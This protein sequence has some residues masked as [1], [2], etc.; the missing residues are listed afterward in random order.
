[1]QTFNKYINID[2]MY[3]IVEIA[4][5]Q[6]KVEKGE[7]IFVH[8]L[9]G[10]AGAEISFD[11]VLLISNNDK[12]NV[13]KP[14]VNNAVVSAQILSH[15]RADKIKVFKKKRRKG[16]KV[17]KGHRQYLTELLIEEISETGMLKK[18]AKKKA[19]QTSQDLV[20]PAEPKAKPPTGKAETSDAAKEKPTEKKTKP[21][22]EMKR[23]E[24][25]VAP[26]KTQPVKKA[27]KESTAA[28]KPDA[29][30]TKST[31]TKK[32]K[33]PSTTVKKTTTKATATKKTTPAKTKPT[34]KKAPV[35]KQGTAG[36]KQD[37]K[38]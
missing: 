20:Q 23:A 9:P 26:A 35:K 4:G 33:T 13:G 32:T 34:A 10:K 29:K 7:K 17:L 19:P 6:F 30:A 11:K 2:L 27:G 15:L 14:Y 25:K 38:K 28:S 5:Q 16:Y 31:A 22:K 36:K 37:T 12:V 1:M 8:Q 18:T 24:A 21:A 3:A